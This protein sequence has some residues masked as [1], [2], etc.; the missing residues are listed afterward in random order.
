MNDKP[1]ISLQEVKNLRLA[2]GKLY[3][4]DLKPKKGIV[5][6]E[7][8]KKF[9]ESIKKA[10]VTETDP[11]LIERTL[12]R[13]FEW[14]SNTT[15]EPKYEQ[16][17]STVLDS[18]RLKVLQEQADERAR[19]IKTATDISNKAVDAFLR[20]QREI[21]EQRVKLQKNVVVVPAQEIQRIT[22]EKQ[23]KEKVYNLAKAIAIDAGTVEV[24]IY[25]KIQEA[26]D[27]SP[28]DVRRAVSVEDI[29]KTTADLIEKI[30]PYGT[31]ENSEE[32]PDNLPTLNSASP[33]TATAPFDEYSQIIAIALE[34]KENLNST[35]VS[36]VFDNSANIIDLLYSSQNV[37][38][39]EVAED[40]ERDD[41]IKLDPE[42]I[43][44]QGKRIKEIWQKLADKTT[45][46]QEVYTSTSTYVMP[47]TPS[48]TA[49][50]AKDAKAFALKALPPAV[51]AIYGF[52]QGALLSQWARSGTP[53]L[54]AGNQNLVRLLTSQAGIQEIASASMVTF[55]QPIGFR[56]GNFAI[57]IRTGS[58]TANG[59]Q[60]AQG[61]IRF[62]EKML[63]IS[64]VKGGTQVAIKVGAQQ[65]GAQATSKLLVGTSTALTKV[66][67]FLGGLSAPITMGI[68]LAVGWVAGKIVEKLPQLKKWLQ[69]NGTALA[70][71]VGITGLMLGGPV[72]GGL[73]LA[74]TLAATGSLS[75]FA[76]GVANASGAIAKAIGIAVATPVIITLLVLPPLV[77]FIMLVIN[78]SA[79]VVPPSDNTS[80]YASYELCEKATCTSD[81]KFCYPVCPA[82]D[83]YFYCSHH[84][85]PASDIFRVGDRPGPGDDKPVTIVAYT[86]GTVGWT[87]ENDGLG[88]FTV[89]VMGDD[90]RFY[91]YAHNERNLV[92]AGQQVVAGQPIALMGS[93]GNAQGTV[94]HVHFGISTVNNFVTARCKPGVI[95]PNCITQEEFEET[96]SHFI[97]PASEFADKFDIQCPYQTP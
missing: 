28:E 45:T 42:E 68:G 64:A 30:K 89:M 74:G 78:N 33:F 67:T 61:G 43:R 70:G 32:I 24:E 16:V 81:G 58:D 57:A 36:P 92:T 39:F 75:S 47:H 79:Y 41:G 37:T 35:L 31:V 3:D 86:A 87:Q 65:V 34:A 84:D 14:Y 52:K 9:N 19:Q 53:L 25:K 11:R 10:G 66:L 54:S 83:S 8:V 23:E 51:G 77:A 18:E 4:E 26:L 15:E 96:T 82:E 94:E 1:T 55:S 44:E 90:G 60:I 12:E 80:N 63:G 5:F 88:G 46:V 59:I 29:R 50:V 97:Q 17:D 27:N 13:W 91:Y 38:Q 71:V 56:L 95:N 49:S 2:F 72:V 73:G 40:Q 93:S 48:V 85:Y 76:T 22:L 20:R 6:S 7:E 62:G 21:Y 69:E